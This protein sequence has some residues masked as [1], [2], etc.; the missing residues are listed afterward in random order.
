VLW[1]E[2][3]LPRTSTGKVRR[4]AVAQWLAGVQAA[5]AG[6]AHERGGA[7]AA[8]GTQTDWLLALIAQITGESPPGV[9][10]ELRLSEDL[11]L[12]SLGRAQLNAALDERLGTGTDSGV[13]DQA[14]T[15]GQ[16]RHLLTGDGQGI[17]SPTGERKPEPDEIR[18]TPG[19]A[20]VSATNGGQNT[21]REAAPA[22]AFSPAKYI[23][24]RWPW[25][26]PFQWM[27]AAFVEGLMRPLVWLLAQPAV[28]ATRNP[29][30]GAAEPMLI[31]ANHVSAFDGPLLEY[32]L[33]GPVRRRMA[34]A[35]SGEMLEDLR[36][37]RNPDRV[38]QDGRFYLR[39][40]LY[41]FLVTAFF[42]VFPLHRQRDFQRAFEHAGAALDRGFNVLV[43]PEGSRSQGSLARFRPGIGLLVK[44]STAPVLPMAI[45][46]LDDL[47]AKRR[48]WFRSGLIEVRIGE[49]M[50]FGPEESETGI[51]ERLHAEVERL[52]LGT[53]GP[54]D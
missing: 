38:P 18:E 52:L 28:V 24:P 53:E 36:H 14:Q 20:T 51:T 2:P 23:Y 10:D 4:K 21:A 31:I 35:M 48:S 25:M 22:A 12:D 11:H 47:K 41:Y 8:V 40:P 43:F 13:L 34:V 15:L 17:V 45:R 19:P 32:A 42:N 46:G 29:A 3:D 16:L 1:P 49:P 6:S 44:Q 5:A 54:R 30:A 9:G 26:A 37:F 27:R 39:G 33:P 50:R 7:A